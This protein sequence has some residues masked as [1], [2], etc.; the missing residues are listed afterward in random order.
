MQNVVQALGAYANVTFEHGCDVN[1]S[2]TS[3]FAAAAA[4][5]AAAQ[6]T[7]LVVGIT[8][9][10]EN[11]GLDR[12]NIALTGVQGEFIAQTCAASAGPCVLVFMG[13]GSLDLSEVQANPNVSAILW[14]GYPGQSGAVAIAQTIYGD[15]VP[16]GRLTQTIYPADYVNQVSMF[17]MNMRPGASIYPPYSSP[18]RSYRFYTG[19]V[20]GPHAAAAA[21]AAGIRHPPSAML[22]MLP[23]RRCLVTALQPC[24]A[25]LTL[26]TMQPVLPF[27]YG[28]SYTT[29]TY[30]VIAAEEHVS[31][32]PTLR[33]LAAH[34]EH[35]AL[36]A[37]LDSDVVNALVVNVTNTGAVDADDVV[38]AFL[39]TPGNGTNGIPI[40][41]VFDFQRV[42][43]P[44]GQTVTVYLYLQA[45]HLTRI[46]S[47][48][49]RVAV[50]GRYTVRFGV[51]AP[52]MHHAYAH[53]TVQ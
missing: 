19:Q 40:Q 27:G 49:K 14:T 37:P 20:C 25:A 44:A 39:Q 47:A 5:A 4:A 11:E 18:G 23:M 35:D 6:A 29:F 46:T 38:I 2:D 52:G 22:P 26:P 32:K 30:T 9:T 41:E 10:E 28:L 17:E 51:D 1:S 21:A 45:R 53:F 16:A 34:P 7:I 48:G 24:V 3:G 42:H 33:Y 12:Y 36:Y 8:G 31:L 13:G 43:V 15:N 50:A